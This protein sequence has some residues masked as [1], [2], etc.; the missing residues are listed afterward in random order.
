MNFPKPFG[1]IFHVK[2]FIFGQNCQGINIYHG[3]VLNNNSGIQRFSHFD[4]PTK[5]RC[6]TEITNLISMDITNLIP[7]DMVF[8]SIILLMLIIY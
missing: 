3:I 4:M 6:L 8:D 2:T 1:F 7:M 5:Y